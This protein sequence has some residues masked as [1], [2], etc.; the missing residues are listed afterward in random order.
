VNTPTVHELL[1][2][3]TRQ[4]RC[5][6]WDVSALDGP[7]LAAAWPA[8]AAH[9][10]DALSAVP[11]PDVGTRLL[12]IRAAGPWRSPNRWGPPVDADPDPHLVSAGQ[13]LVAVAE[14]LRRHASPPRSPQARHDAD[15]VCRRIAECLLVGS[16]ATALGLA[17]H[18]TRLRPARPGIAFERPGM[19][20]AVNGATLA[21][22]RRLTAKLATFEAHL[23]HYLAQTPQRAPRHSPEHFA[24][25][26]QLPH[27]LAQWEVTAMRVLHAQPPSVRDLAG[28]AHTEQALLVHA[29]VILDVGARTQVID[30]RDVDHHIRARLQG[31]QTGWGD[32][33]A[34]WP[35][36]MTTTAPPSLACLQASAQLHAAL[37]EITREG[38][39]WAT[40]AQIASHVHLAEVSALLRDAVAAQGTRAERFAELPAELAQAGQLHAPARL[41]AALP[42]ASAWGGLKPDSAV[43]T[44]DVANR[45]ILVVRP[46]Q[47]TRATATARDLGRQ[48]ATL[49]AALETLPLDRRSLA[50]VGSESTAQAAARE[51]RLAGPALAHIHRD[52]LAP[53]SG[54]AG[55]RL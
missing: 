43:R 50:V 2:D 8:F 19:R 34:T 18:A 26:D 27:A 52:L 21:Q 11:V 14:L 5:I 24:E 6:M 46:D 28:I 37:N 35:A 31:A 22:S 33:A 17:E 39:G 12:I 20:L 25:P 44:T 32:V 29:A 15:A 30:T 16:H 53:T 3:A 1:H 38:N 7:G 55:R 40:P 51:V 13:A 47:T 9:A 23:S 45:R 4:V 42:P 10:R 36:Q 49:T 54:S 48:L 41:L